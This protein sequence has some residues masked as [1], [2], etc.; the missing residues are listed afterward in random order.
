MSKEEG[1]Y[2]LKSLLQ[3]I[4]NRIKEIG[5]NQSMVYWSIDYSKIDKAH[6]EQDFALSI[7]DKL[8]QN[9]QELQDQCKTAESNT[10]EQPQK[11]IKIDQDS[12]NKTNIPKQNNQEDIQVHQDIDWTLVQ[13]TANKSEIDRRISAFMQ[14]KQ[15]EVNLVNIREFCNIVENNQENVGSCAR[16]DAIFVPRYGQ[17]SHIKVTRVGNTST[18][19]EAQALSHVTDNTKLSGNPKVTCT[20]SRV[21][22]RLHNIEHHLG[23]TPG[24]PVPL[25]VYERIRDLESR[26]L[27]LESLSPEYFDKNKVCQTSRSRASN[28]SS[29]ESMSLSTI[30]ERISALKNMLLNRSR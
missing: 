12:L 25:D 13:V 18:S 2:V 22:E 17:K 11:K 8:I 28:S 26:I 30:D 10:S 27:H 1:K 14:Q 3:I 23:F 15:N 19:D 7:I 5:L 16:T 4:E 9:L 20:E 24:K 21:T 29:L 6:V